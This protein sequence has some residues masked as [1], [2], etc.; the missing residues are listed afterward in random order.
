MAVER[1]DVT[2]VEVVAL[3]HRHGAAKLFVVNDDFRGEVLVGIADLQNM[4]QL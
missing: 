4:K 3:V 1:Q 2:N